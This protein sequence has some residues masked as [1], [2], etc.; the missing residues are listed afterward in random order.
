MVATS[1]GLFG[2]LGANQ[3]KLNTRKGKSFLWGGATR[4]MQGNDLK[5]N[6]KNPS[7]ATLKKFR[8]QLKA[9]SALVRQKQ[10]LILVNSVLLAALAV[11]ILV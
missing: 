1:A 10:L 4:R 3:G 7:K 8:K 2:N 6:Y 9:E 5:V 11:T